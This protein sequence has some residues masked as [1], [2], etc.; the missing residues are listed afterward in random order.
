MNIR[1][2]LILLL[3]GPLS[4]VAFAQAPT[5]VMVVGMF[6][7]NNPGRDLHNMRVDDVL[8]PKPQAE[9]AAVVDAVA[10][11]HPTKVAVEWPPDVV[12]QRYEQFRKGTLA[13]SRD[14]S[15]QLG[16]RLAKEL[17][18]P[19]YGIDVDGDFPYAAVAAY[20]KAHGE[21]ALLDSGGADVQAEVDRTSTLLAHGTVGQTVRDIN[22]P[23]N[24]RRG[25]NFY[26]LMLK[27]GGGAQQPGADLL[28]AWYKRNFYIC[29][30][31]VQLSRPG[32]R[33]VVFYGAGHAFLLRQCV[34]EMPGYRL[35]EANDY[36]PD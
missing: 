13:P 3:A 18:I 1:L 24:I 10:Q 26:R 22:T 4:S 34:S 12:A 2:F 14:E 35:I 16:F 21:Q 9:I 25:Q 15:V 11:F 32:D 29:A 5:E 36:L 31:L 27:I 8:A 30:N 33:V 17:Q 28:A 23:D 7:M 20:A 6:H 19:V